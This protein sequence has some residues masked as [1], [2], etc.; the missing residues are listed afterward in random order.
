MLSPFE[1]STTGPAASRR[2]ATI[3]AR[4]DDAGLDE[5]T[6]EGTAAGEAI[7]ADAKADAGASAEV[8]GGEGTLGR[9]AALPHPPSNVPTATPRAAERRAVA[10]VEAMGAWRSKGRERILMRGW[11]ERAGFVDADIR[12]FLLE[13]VWP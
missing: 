8:V 1:S 12:S 10:A 7:A 3:L 2:C 5:G 6:V 4:A 13:P 9:S 11:F